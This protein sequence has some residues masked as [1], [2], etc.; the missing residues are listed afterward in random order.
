MVWGRE[1]RVFLGVVR[2]VCCILVS[3]LVISC[4][5]KRVGKVKGPSFPQGDSFTGLASWYGAEYHGRATASGEIYD[6]Y[7]LTAAHL[8]LPFGSQ[9]RVTHLEN[10]KAVNVRINDR[11]PFIE[12][13]I[14]DLSYGAAR[15]LNMVEEGVAP[16]NLQLEK[17]GSAIGE[18]TVQVGSFQNRDNAEKFRDRLIQNRLQAYITVREAA[19]ATF[20]QVRVGSYSN[21]KTAE[22]AARKLKVD[23]HPTFITRADRP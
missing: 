20:Y 22:Q 12:G 17:E 2:G 11:G 1:H 6:M 9:V 13:R 7:G 10:S 19:G 5:G 16:V 23:G 18:Y 21:R 4:A 3:S 15:V 8:T 14:I